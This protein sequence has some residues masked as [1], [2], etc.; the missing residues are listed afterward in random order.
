[1][2][3]LYCFANAE[4][5]RAL[6]RI[7][8]NTACFQRVDSRQ[9]PASSPRQGG[10]Q[11]EEGGEQAEGGGRRLVQGQVGGDADERGDG[12]GA[13]RPQPRPQPP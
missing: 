12:G 1:M 6:L 11:G 5:Q 4:V 2:A 8:K 3:I 10:G 13:A 7:L 9:T